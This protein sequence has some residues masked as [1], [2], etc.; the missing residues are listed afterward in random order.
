VEVTFDNRDNDWGDTTKSATAARGTVTFS[1]G[2][3]QGAT[4]DITI[5]VF[6]T[7]GAVADTV[8]ITDTSDGAS[9]TDG[10][11]T[12]GDSP[13]FAGTVVDDLGG[14]EANYEVSYNVS[15]RSNFGTVRVEY[16]NLDSGGADATYTSTDP[17]H[18]IDDYADADFGGTA[19]DEYRI[20]V[21][22]LDAEGVVV[23]ERVLTDVADGSDPSGNADLARSTSPSLSDASIG[24]RTKNNNGDYRVQYRVADP[25]GDFSQLEAA[26]V[27]ADNAWATRTVSRSIAN[28]VLQYREGGVGGDEYRIAIRVRDSDGIVVDEVVVTDVAD[29]NDP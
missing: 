24:D 14:N 27:N 11:V 13:S 21:E 12:D 15:D 22:L 17:R 9:Q 20:R 4:Y 6:D 29:G 10:D 8:S 19:G 16:T 18:N 23:E 25:S 7:D 5:R 28:G 1:Q 3:Q 26:F 2:G